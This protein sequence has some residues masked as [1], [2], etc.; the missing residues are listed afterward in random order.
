MKIRYLPSSPKNGTEEHVRNDVGN[1]L[2]AAGFAEALPDPRRGTNEHLQMRA[3]QSR[4]AGAPDK[5]DVVPPRV[6]GVRWE[7][8]QPAPGVVILLRKSGF[9][10][11][12]FV[13]KDFEDTK[14]KNNR[15]VETGRQKFL[16]AVRACPQSVLKQYEDHKAANPAA[17]LAQLEQAKNAHANYNH[18]VANAKRW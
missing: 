6:E 2:V 8:F 13:E 18:S 3:E 16:D 10:V 14:D 1:T 5:N 11:T 15:V 4:L 7:I 12:F 9:E 17:N